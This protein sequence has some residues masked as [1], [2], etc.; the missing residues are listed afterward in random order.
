M[1]TRL[2]LLA[3]EL[4]GWNDQPAIAPGK[5]T[6][7]ERIFRSAAAAVTMDPTTALA[8][9]ATSTGAPLPDG[10]RARF[11]RSLDADLGGVRIH[12]DAPAAD[13]A[14]G[15]GGAF[16]VGQ[17]VHFGAGQYRPDDPFGMHLLAHE[18]AHTVQQRTGGGG[19]QRAAQVS[20]VGDPAEAEADRAADAM[21]RGD[22]YAITG[23]ASA[24]VARREDGA[25]SARPAAAAGQNFVEFT[26]DGRW[27]GAAVLAA[28]SKQNVTVPADLQAAIQAGPKATAK[29]CVALRGRVAAADTDPAKHGDLERIENALSSR[30]NELVYATSN[31]PLQYA[32]LA[33][34]ATWATT[35]PAQ[36]AGAAADKQP[37]A[38]GVRP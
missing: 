7:T 20:E 33:E 1:R 3:E 8:R 24:V 5:V 10:T 14:A 18:V 23:G 11:E 27:D 31:S 6:L 12:T 38:R 9:A 16:A 26:K 34:V 36:G 29:Y 32:Q 21:V 2:D 35:W 13:A 28:L 37:S 25:A 22:H 17:D 15:L 4:E 19:P 30:V